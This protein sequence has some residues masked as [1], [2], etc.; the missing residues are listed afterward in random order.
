MGGQMETQEQSAEWLLGPRWEGLAIE[1]WVRPDGNTM[2]RGHYEFGMAE[3]I[4]YP[5]GR[6]AGVWPFRNSSG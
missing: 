2:R 6:S 1:E 3:E 5:D 4:V